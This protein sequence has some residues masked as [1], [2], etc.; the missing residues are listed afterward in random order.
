[1]S[2]PLLGHSN[3]TITA[4]IYTHTRLPHQ[5]HALG[6]LDTQLDQTPHPRRPAP[7]RPDT[8]TTHDKT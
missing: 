3:I 8:H 7:P 6:Q 5:A 4:N 2:T 1:V